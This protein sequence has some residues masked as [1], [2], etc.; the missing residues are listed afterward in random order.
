MNICITC[1]LKQ[2]KNHKIID[3]DNKNYICNIHNEGYTR[4]R[5]YKKYELNMCL[6][7]ESKHNNHII[8]K[9]KPNLDK[10][11]NNIKEFKENIDIFNNN[12]DNIIN[13][14]NKVK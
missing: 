9:I 5:Y 12:I 14:L 1:K 8:I 11:K 6:S 4:Y 2:D 3:F 10:I 7:Y 13:K